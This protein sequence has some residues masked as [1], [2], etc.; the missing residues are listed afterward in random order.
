MD[1]WAARRPGDKILYRDVGRNP[2]PFIDEDFIAASFTPTD[3]RTVEMR[4]KLTISD[5]LIDELEAAD[6]IVLA[7]PMYNYGM[8]AQLK[9][10]VDQ[11]I[12]INRTFTFD[13]G[14]GDW[15]LAPVLGGKT[16][17]L[18]TSS[19]E[20]GFDPGGVRGSMDHLAT[21]IA[22]L[23]GYLGVAA[24]HNVA[25]EYQEFGDQRHELSLAR[26]RVAVPAL[27]IALSTTVSADSSV[28][29]QHPSRLP[30]A[31]R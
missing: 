16:L 18:L 10:W 3:E 30:E 5:E 31:S 25:V 9:A 13:L 4:A 17:V 20:F 23:A 8:P 12:R 2:P 14:R 28:A 27:A 29:A 1:S 19:G 6:L 22:T 11:V 7:T 24:T 15:P 21:H 26:A